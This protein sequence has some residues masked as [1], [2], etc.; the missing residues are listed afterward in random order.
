MRLFALSETRALG[1]KVAG[2]LSIPLTPIE[3]R[4]FEDG[5][6]KARPMESV[7]GEDAVVVQSLDGGPRLTPNDKLV[8]LLFFASTLKENGA[9]RVTAVIPYL[10]YARKDRQT[11][12]RDPVAS[13]Y[14]AQ[15]LEAAGI[16]VIVTLEVHNI[17]AFQNAFRRQTVHL[18]TRKIFIDRA[19]DLVGQGPVV[20]ASPD[21]GG[22]KRAQLFREMFERRLARPVG[23]AFLDKRRSAG[24]VS[25][26][27]LAGDV[28]ESTV[29]VIDDL[30]ASGSTLARAAARCMEEGAWAVYGFAAHGLFVGE[31]DQTLIESQLARLFVSDSIPPHRLSAKT[32]KNH[33][34]IVSAAPLLA[35]AIRVLHEGGSITT[36]L[37]EEG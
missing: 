7:R 34:E 25:G 24:V 14:I 3:E 30:V 37:G 5:E 15:M 22:V 1:E 13:R 11:K 33:V 18:D 12:P 8:R 26:E 4:A 19:V 16:D 29:L 31:A 27:V 21:P 10:A 23:Q 20:V 2:E 17:V 9:R 28:K 6:H 35:G 36:L 32:L